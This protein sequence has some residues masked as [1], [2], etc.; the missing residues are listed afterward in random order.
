MRGLLVNSPA[1]IVIIDEKTQQPRFLAL[2]GVELIYA[3]ANL[4]NWRVPWK[5]RHLDRTDLNTCFEVL[6]LYRQQPTQ[7]QSLAEQTPPTV[8]AVK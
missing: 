6:R 3:H 1:Y 8:I 5:V 4:S 7:K 2:E